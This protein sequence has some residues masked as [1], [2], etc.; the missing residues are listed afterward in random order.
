MTIEKMAPKKNWVAP[1]PTTCCP[2]NPKNK[3]LTLLCHPTNLHK[4]DYTSIYT[5]KV[6]EN[7]LDFNSG[8]YTFVILLLNAA[9]QLWAGY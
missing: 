2:N 9:R 3:V 7:P 6:P 4:L 8:L 5:L 1:H